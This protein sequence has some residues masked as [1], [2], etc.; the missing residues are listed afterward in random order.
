LIYG[1]FGLP[2]LGKPAAE[3]GRDRR[4]YLVDVRYDDLVDATRS[5]VSC[6]QSVFISSTA[7]G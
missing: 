5:G 2:Q 7:L 6:D 4:R 3:R 1:H